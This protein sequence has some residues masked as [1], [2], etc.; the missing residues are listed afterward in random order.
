MRACGEDAGVKKKGTKEGKSD[1]EGS[2]VEEV[3]TRGWV[4]RVR[5][6]RERRIIRGKGGGEGRRRVEE[7]KRRSCDEQDSGALAQGKACD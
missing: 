6:R 1:R 5:R 4:K 3:K 2:L 7:S